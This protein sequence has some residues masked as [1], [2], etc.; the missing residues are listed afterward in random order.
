MAREKYPVDVL[1]EYVSSLERRVVKLQNEVI[2]LKMKNE[3]LKQWQNEK[4]KK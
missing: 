2:N 1:V 3:E 4:K